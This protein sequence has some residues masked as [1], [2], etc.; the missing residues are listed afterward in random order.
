MKYSANKEINT[1][2]KEKVRE[3]WPFKWGRKH[4]RLTHPQGFPTITVP[5]SPSDHRSAK[6]FRC[7]IKRVASQNLH[8]SC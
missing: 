4:G 8:A 2:V 3:G 5:K 1:I 7:E 6:N